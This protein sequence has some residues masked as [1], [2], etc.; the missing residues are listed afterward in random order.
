L[1]NLLN[2]KKLKLILSPRT[3]TAYRLLG[4]S[5]L[6]NIEIAGQTSDRQ[7]ELETMSLDELWS[8]QSKARNALET[9]LR[10]FILQ[11]LRLRHGD[12]GWTSH[13]L[14]AI[15]KER[16]EALDGK[17]GER[18]MKETYFSDLLNIM[19]RNW[20][21]FEMLEKA[22]KQERV[23]KSEIETLMNFIN[24]HREDCHAGNVT[25]AQ[26]ALVCIA[27]E[28]IQNAI[29]IYLDGRQPYPE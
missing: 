24:T 15:P 9:Q 19:K 29:S 16:R 8:R 11:T 14:A 6:E 12:P 22:R 4:I 1:V 28:N 5:S 2:G 18:I 20:A 21:D 27:C 13:V 17:D 3:Y 25:N 10:K 23:S 26:V 7:K